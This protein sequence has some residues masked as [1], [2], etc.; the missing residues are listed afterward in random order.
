VLF[1]LMEYANGGTLDH[2]LH[3]PED[4]HDGTGEPEDAHAAGEVGR[5][6]RMPVAPAC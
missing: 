5:A 3:V 4:D 1:I 6:A 2:L